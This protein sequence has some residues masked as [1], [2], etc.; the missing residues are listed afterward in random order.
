MENEVKRQMSLGVILSYAVIIAQFATGLLYTPI[1]LKT[2]GQSQ[3]G[4]YSLCTSFIG[5][6]TL[7][8]SGANAAYIRFYVQTKVNEP[9]KIS[10]LNGTF[11]KIFVVLEIGRASC[12]E[13][14]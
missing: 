12:R 5:Y 13:R 10:S 6:L 2:L 1:V 4:V 7:M 8:N 3:Y 11:L 14:V 9:K